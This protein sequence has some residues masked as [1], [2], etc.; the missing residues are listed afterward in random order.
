LTLTTELEPE[1][2]AASYAR[3]WRLCEP[4]ATVVVFH[5]NEYGDDVSVEWSEPS[6]KS[7]TR[8]TPTLSLALAET[9]TVPLT[10]APLA[11]D[12]ID[13]VGGVVS[14]PPPP[15]NSV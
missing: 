14:P 8:L 4:F 2:P 11:G 12:V 13:V 6:T 10:V 7:S 5:E 15:P 3:V 1:L 9:V